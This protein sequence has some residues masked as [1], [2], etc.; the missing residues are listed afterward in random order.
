MASRQTRCTMIAR[1]FAAG[2]RRAPVK[3]VMDPVRALRYCM[4]GFLRT[5]NGG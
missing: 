4:L 1:A 5:A 3:A 2:A